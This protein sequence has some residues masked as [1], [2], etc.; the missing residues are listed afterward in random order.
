MCGIYVLP[1][2]QTL[3]DFIQY[4]GALFLSNTDHGAERKKY[5]QSRISSSPNS[6]LR[7]P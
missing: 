1:K 2:T 7:L 6:C 3:R 5:G 4:V